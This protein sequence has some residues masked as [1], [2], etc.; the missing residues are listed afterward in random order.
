MSKYEP[1]LR[2]VARRNAQLMAECTHEGLLYGGPDYFVHG[3]LPCIHHTFAHAKALA[4]VLDR[5]SFLAE[6]KPQPVLPRDEPY[7]LKTFSVIGTRLA[8]IGPWRATVTDYDWEYVE[9]VQAGSGGDSGGG[10]AS[11]GALSQLYHVGLGPVLAA[12]M[13]K[14]AMIEMS[15]QQQFRDAPHMTLTSRIECAG[16]ETY[17]SLDDL[18]AVVTATEHAGEI[19]FDAK[20]RLLT[21]EHKS[22]SDGEV[23][24]HLIYKLSEQGVEIVASTSGTGPAPLRLILPVIAR[25]DE[26]FVQPD[27]RTVRISKAKGTL[28]VT[29]DAVFETVPRERTFNLVPGFEAIPL[30][31]VLEAGKET[32]IRIEGLARTQAVAA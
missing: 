1:R 21:T 28:T 32:R 24:Y 12:S 17:T 18:K 14:Y 9:D 16:K 26:E 7:G 8:A 29:T 2:E 6:T 30:E 11:G 3:D 20:G 22:V 31:V 27:A 23:L 13:T 25:A 4:T 10:H 15:N 19:V 5:C